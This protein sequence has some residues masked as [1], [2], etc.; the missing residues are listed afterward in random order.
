[1]IERFAFEHTERFAMV[2]TAGEKN[3]GS[4]E[5]VR[6]K[7]SEHRAL[8][9]WRKMEEAVPRDQTVKPLTQIQVAHV[10][11]VEGRSC[12]ARDAARDHCG[13]AVNSGEVESSAN[14]ISANRFTGATAKVENAA[15]G[16]QKIEKSVQPRPLDQRAGPRIVP[17]RGV[18]LV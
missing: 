9:L 7:N 14:D 11:D 18:A 10:G 8:I 17:R 15:L 1:M 6:R 3:R 13:R 12:E 5:S 16:R 2:G 4:R